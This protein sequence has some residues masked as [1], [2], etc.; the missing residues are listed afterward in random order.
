MLSITSIRFMVAANGLLHR[1]H[2]QSPLYPKMT[3]SAFVKS[4]PYITY[5]AS[6]SLAWM[7][8]EMTAASGQGT[9]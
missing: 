6:T 7:A 9:A 5:I 8:S 3:D 1:D 4:R 2:D